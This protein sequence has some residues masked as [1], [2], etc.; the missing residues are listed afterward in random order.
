MIKKKFSFFLVLFYFF[1]NNVSAQEKIAF[2]DL[3]YVYSN[4]KIGKK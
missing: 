2:I 4:S 3:N 1:F